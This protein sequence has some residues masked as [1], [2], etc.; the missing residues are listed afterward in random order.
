MDEVCT[1]ARGN[2]RFI[3]R[4]IEGKGRFVCRYE[5]FRQTNKIICIILDLNGVYILQNACL[6][7]TRLAQEEGILII[8]II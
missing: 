5:D 2:C 1:F 3:T 6:L 7:Q 4:Y 8:I